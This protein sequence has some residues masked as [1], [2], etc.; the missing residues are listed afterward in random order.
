[1]V[2]NNFVENFILHMRSS[3]MKTKNQLRSEK[4]FVLFKSN[5]K[6]YNIFFHWKTR[7]LIPVLWIK[8]VLYQIQNLTHPFPR[9]NETDISKCLYLGYQNCGN[10]K[11]KDLCNRFTSK[12]LKRIFYW[13]GRMGTYVI[14]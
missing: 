6:M 9:T 7:R 14:L 1:M 8:V 12:Y 10:Y 4:I 5:C 13:N 3:K 2:F 11:K